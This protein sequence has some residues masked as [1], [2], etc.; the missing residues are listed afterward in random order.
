[1]ALG[2]R[3]DRRRAKG[4]WSRA[5]KEQGATG[6]VGLDPVLTPR[7]SA[8]MLGLVWNPGIFVCSE[9]DRLSQA[10]P[11]WLWVAGALSLLCVGLGSVRSRPGRSP[12]LLGPLPAPRPPTSCRQLTVGFKRSHSGALVSVSL[13][14]SPQVQGL[15]VTAAF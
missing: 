14:P 13:L 5:R 15:A 7:T 1:M 11:G 2:P 4:S 8:L 10:R 6:S 3:P 12:A 9:G